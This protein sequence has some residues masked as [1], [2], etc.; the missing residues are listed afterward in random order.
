MKEK[1]KLT[2]P[3]SKLSITIFQALKECFGSVDRRFLGIQHINLG[4]STTKFPEAVAQP[5]NT[6][7]SKPTKVN[8]NINNLCKIYMTKNLNLTC[9]TNNTPQTPQIMKTHNTPQ[10]R[11]QNT[12]NENEHEHLGASFYIHTLFKIGI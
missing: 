6:Y 4:T 3:M 2:S 10:V 11:T 9:Q 12:P 5:W 7:T 8:N 1:R